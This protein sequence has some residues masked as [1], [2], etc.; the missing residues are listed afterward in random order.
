MRTRSG[1]VLGN[2]DLIE[3][4]G[5]ISREEVEEEVGLALIVHEGLKEVGSKKL[6]TEE[7]KNK[8]EMFLRF[9]KISREHGIMKMNFRGKM[10]EKL[11]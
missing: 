8:L 9:R 10:G 6:K 4:Q 7:F 11:F 5:L 1:R 2:Q 3:E